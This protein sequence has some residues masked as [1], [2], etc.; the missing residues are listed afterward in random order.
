VKAPSPRD[1]ITTRQIVVVALAVK[2][3]RR[4]E[5][6]VVLLDEQTGSQIGLLAGSSLGSFV[7]PSRRMALYARAKGAVGVRLRVAE[8]MLEH[9]RP[10]VIRV[11]ATANSRATSLDIPVRQ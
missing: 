5:L 11:T 10:L 1:S 6:R 8:R 4:A 7:T 9:G 3:D 2:V